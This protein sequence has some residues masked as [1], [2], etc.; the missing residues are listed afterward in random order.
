MSR[1]RRARDG[2]FRMLN[3]FDTTSPELATDRPRQTLEHDRGPAGMTRCEK[4]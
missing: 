4:G 2:H 3:R 1:G